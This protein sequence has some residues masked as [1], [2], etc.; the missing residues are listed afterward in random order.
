MMTPEQHIA[1]LIVYL[2]TGARD[3]EETVEK[4]RSVAKA[5]MC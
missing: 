2:L 5:L 1:L 4:I 3:K